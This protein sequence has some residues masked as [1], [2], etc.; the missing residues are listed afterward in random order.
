M[1]QLLAQEATLMLV[2]VVLSLCLIAYVVEAYI[3]RYSRPIFTADSQRVGREL[4]S[5]KR[6]I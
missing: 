6:R 5:C 1:R 3:R 4:V 2:M